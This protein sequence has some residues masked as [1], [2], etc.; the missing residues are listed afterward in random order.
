MISSLCEE[1]IGAISLSL[2]T[3]HKYDV[4]N[5]ESSTGSIEGKKETKRHPSFPRGTL[6]SFRVGATSSRVVTIFKI[7]RKKVASPLVF[8]I[9]LKK[10]KKKRQNL[11]IAIFPW[12]N[13][14]KSS[15]RYP[16]LF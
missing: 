15:S 4:R 14:N 8:I 7:I 5:L 2:V 16:S 11:S 13:Q 1:R 6:A 12:I 9:L 10:K 3:V